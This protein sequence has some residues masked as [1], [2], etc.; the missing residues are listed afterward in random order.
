MNTKCN[1]AVTPQM[2]TVKDFGVRYRIS[3]AT[4][5]RLLSTGALKAKKVGNRI[6][7]PIAEIEA[8]EKQLPVAI[9]RPSISPLSRV[10]NDN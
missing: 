1:L 7:L 10:A 4:I 2:L 5:Y 9:F 8:W 3:R 6:L